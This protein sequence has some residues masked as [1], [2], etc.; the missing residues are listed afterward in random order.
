MIPT[1]FE[2][3]TLNEAKFDL[4]YTSNYKYQANLGLCSLIFVKKIPTLDFLK[5]S[6]NDKNWN[7][8]K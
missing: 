6:N 5:S 7:P 8:M 4:D 3:K 1:A 2:K